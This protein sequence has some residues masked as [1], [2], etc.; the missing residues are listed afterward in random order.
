MKARQLPSKRWRVQTQDYKDEKGKWHTKSFTA[1]TAEE[2]EYA[3]LK[4]KHERTEGGQDGAI[5][6]MVERAI[7]QKAPA[8]SPSTLRGYRKILN[9]QIKPCFFGK[10]RVYSVETRHVQQ[11]ISWMIGEGLSPKSIKNALGVFTSCYQY[12]GGEKVFRVKIPQ[13]SARRRRVP[14]IAEVKMVMRYFADDPDMK[15]AIV[16]CA[17]ASLRR[18][19]ACALM[20][21]DVDRERK[22]ILVNKAVTETE[23]GEWIV[24]V[25][26]T[27]SSVRYVEVSDTVLVALPK[28][29]KC[30]NL[31][32]Y[33]VT[34]RFYR[35][36][37]RLPVVPFSYHDLRHFYA[38]YAH[39]KG[40]SDITLQASSGWSSQATMK[41][42]YWGEIDEESKA[43]M[44][45]FNKCVDSEFF[46]I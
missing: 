6:D 44:A 42:T 25:P 13:A 8:L 34:N 18:G 21:R 3:A 23:S 45:K 37:R 10:V 22:R 43:Q 15:A 12:F 27:E 36:V 9:N 2:A 32:P 35:A 29:G 11:W 4:F 7:R 26:K 46:G 41:E 19:E 30:V 39:N 38:S 1:D 33:E 28:K 20:A 16:L 14:S 17:F 40:V 31:K 24:K 5:Y